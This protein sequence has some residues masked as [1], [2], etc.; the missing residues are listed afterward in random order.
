MQFQQ[1]KIM[2]DLNRFY[3]YAY[4]REDRTPYYIGKGSGKRIYANV[5][6]PCGKPKDKSRIIF[7][8][9]N[10][11]EEEAFKHEIYMIAVLGR[12]DLGTGILHNKSNGGQGASGLIVTDEMKKHQSQLRKGKKNPKHSENMKRE[13]N[14]MFGKKRTEKEKE[15]LSNLFKGEKSPNYGVPK[16]PE[17]RKKISEAQLGE[18]NHR[19]GKKWTEEEKKQASEKMK[20][21]VAP[22]SRRKHTEEEN[23]KKRQQMVGRQ[24]WNNGIEDR[25]L[26][27]PPDETWNLGRLSKT[28]PH[29]WE[30]ISPSKIAYV[31]NNL[32]SFCKEQFNGKPSVL[33]NVAY[34][35]R[36]HYKGWKCRKLTKYEYA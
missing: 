14:P 31:T 7:L 28:L 8:K 17:V 33:A 26:Y 18:K 36:K 11:T 24:W 10:L 12:K 29:M 30:I 4:L 6:R 16:P 27:L 15:H 13:K 2:K 34:G 19:Y 9:Q 32:S 5:G 3:T 1:N 35:I 20:G 22:W 23:D 21:R 25:F